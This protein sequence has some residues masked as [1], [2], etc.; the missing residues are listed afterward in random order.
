M[1]AFDKNKNSINWNL[2]KKKVKRNGVWVRVEKQ[3][4]ISDDDI[5]YITF[6]LVGIGNGFYRFDNIIFRKIK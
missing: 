6:R 3:F 1:A 2:F 4:N 5:K